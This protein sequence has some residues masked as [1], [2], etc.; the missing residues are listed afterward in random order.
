MLTYAAYSRLRYKKV[1][2]RSFLRRYYI[3]KNVKRER[4]VHL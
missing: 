1:I 4:E 2:L 3:Y